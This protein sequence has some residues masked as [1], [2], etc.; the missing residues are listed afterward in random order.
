ME[1]GHDIGPDE[2]RLY[3]VQMITGFHETEQ[4]EMSL[5]YEKVFVQRS[6]DGTFIE[7]FDETPPTHNTAA[8]SVSD[9]RFHDEKE[10]MQTFSGYWPDV[11]PVDPISLAKNGFV[12]IGPGDRVKCV[13]CLNTLRGWETG[14]VVEDEHRRHYPDCPFVRGAAANVVY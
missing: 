11:Y 10:R 6:A 1:T 3:P 2:E 9:P 7:P 4:G 13:F 14:D 5:A 8:V 12:F